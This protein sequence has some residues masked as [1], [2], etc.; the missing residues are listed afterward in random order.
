MKQGAII[1][2]VQIRKVRFQEVKWLALVAKG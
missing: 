1:P 2:T